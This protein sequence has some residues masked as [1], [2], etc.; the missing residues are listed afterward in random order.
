[1]ENLQCPNCLSLN[2]EDSQYCSKCG[3]SLEEKEETISYAPDQEQTTKERIHYS[4]GQ[5]FGKRYIIIEEIGRGGMG[6]VYKAEDKELGTTVALKVIKPKYSRNKHFIERF[7]K[8][9]LLARSI[10]H[11]N[12]IRIHDIGEVEGTKYISMD[13]IKGQNLRD[14]IQSS[15]K[16][17]VETAF[18]ITF[19][20]CEALKAAHKKGIIHRDL[21]PQNI[22][23][24]KNG[25]A[26]VMDFGL[27]KALQVQEVATQRAIV[28]TPQ[29]MSPEQAR[30]EKADKSSDIYAL[31][32]IIYEMLTGKP[33]FQAK[34]TQGYFTKH[35]YENPQEPSKINPRIPQLLEK[36]ILKCLEKDRKK[37]FQSVDELLI[38]LEKYKKVL[39]PTLIS[40]K[41]KSWIVPLLAI[42]I[43]ILAG[44]SILLWNTRRRTEVLSPSISTKISVAVLYFENHTGKEELNNWRKGL[45][46]TIIQDLLQSKYLHVIPGDKLFSILRELNLHEAKSYSSEDLKR[47]A[48]RGK[49]DNILYGYYSKAENTY[50]IDV[51]LKNVGSGEIIGS[52]KL[53][54]EGESIFLTK[55]DELTPWIKSKLNLSELEIAADLDRD[56]GQILTSSPEAMNYYTLGK[57]YYQEMKYEESKDAFEKAI[58]ADPGF[59]FAYRS[60]SES[61][62]YLGEIELAKEYAQKAL[63]LLE[64]DRISV[65]NRY[66]I[67]A[68]AFTILGDS[69][70]DALES[71]E[72]LLQY[73]PDDEVGN[74]YL[75][76][77]YRN[78]EE[79][80]LA[81]ERYE[82]IKQANPQIAY[83]NIVFLYTAKG[84]YDKAKEILGKNKEIYVNQAFYHMNMALLNLCQGKYDLALSESKNGL[85]ID[86]DYYDNIELMG[87][88]YHLKGDFPASEI[89]Y[90]RLISMDDPNCNLLGRLWLAYL[91]LSQGKYGQ[92]KKEL[93]QGLK[94]SQKFNRKLEEYEFSIFLA[95][96]C[97][98]KNQ[99]NET[100]EHLN[101]AEDLASGMALLQKEIKVKHFRGIALLRAN[102]TDGAKSNAEELR[103]L[104]EKQGIPKQMRYYHHLKGVI[105]FNDHMTSNA[106]EHFEEA[107]SMLPH[108]FSQYDDH[109]F[110][111]HSLAVFYFQIGEMDKAREY[112]ER[113]VSLTTGRLQWGDI[114]AKSFYWLGKVFQSQGL[115]NRSI[116]NYQKFLSRWQNADPDIP[117]IG[118]ARKELDVL[119]NN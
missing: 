110:Y 40:F 27:A 6:K 38:D 64:E 46:I 44:V 22:M 29:Y 100:L 28:G 8:E 101:H 93:M 1:M 79:W 89:A 60:L 48:E 71:Y 47:I 104:I 81:L 86:P 95:N 118:E 20:I 90:Q 88:T 30:G 25:N 18:N 99:M 91:N 23:I 70:D 42:V 107:V 111:F 116:E 14:L 75:G 76:S 59:V 9:T 55:V 13:Y 63:L 37:R 57:Q 92:C 50:Q 53:Q 34:T 35:L 85:S 96:I 31:G 97:L 113:T 21:K 10:S 105:S 32:T 115:T 16:L 19:D 109:A 2:P 106:A 67:Q 114:Y 56:I 69:Y 52:K 15:G 49:V 54:G 5:N 4:P 103:K 26:Y 98:I 45:S 62:H 117:E 78:M 24:D 66:L 112:L 94:D 3:S 87:H 119:R 73:Y 58:A 36:S 108:Q 11:E 83:A 68:W 7:K 77:I 51:N 72:K 43:V 74:I 80:D 17:T 12:V 33:V 41:K 84:L 82:K 65:R 61:Y 39:E 102:F